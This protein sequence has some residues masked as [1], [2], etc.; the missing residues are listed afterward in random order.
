MWNKVFIWFFRINSIIWVF[1]APTIYLLWKFGGKETIMIESTENSMPILILL[2]I[3]LFVLI[4]V[5]WL[6]SQA[7]VVYWEYVKKHPFGSVSVF[8]FGSVILALSVLIIQWINKFTDLIE[9]NAERF[10]LDLEVY[11]GSLSVIVI[12]VSIGLACAVTSFIWRKATE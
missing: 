8:T 10:T 1:I 6:G 3:S 5:M 12:Y 11:R 4:T 7:I 2:V 9:Y